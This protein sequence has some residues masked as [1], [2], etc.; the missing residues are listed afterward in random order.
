MF[1]RLLARGDAAW[2][3]RAMLVALVAY[4]LSPIDLVPDF[5]PVAGQVD[6][7][8]IVAAALAV[9]LRRHGE[10]VIRSAWPGPES[11][12]RV[13]LRAAGSAPGA[14]RPTATL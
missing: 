11:S 14:N 4:L 9:L 2:W 13:V 8:A 12:L 1:R 3:E 10:A 7:A 5:I 6:D